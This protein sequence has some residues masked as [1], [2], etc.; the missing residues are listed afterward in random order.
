MNKLPIT[1]QGFEKLSQELKHLKMIE[2]PAVITALAEAKDY[3]DLL[4]NSDYYAAKE[5]QG[6]IEGR[7][8][9]LEDK[10][11]RSEIIDVSKLS[12]DV[13]KFG[14]KVNLV[15]LNTDKQVSYQIVGEYE[16]A[17]EN[18][19]ISLHAPIAKAMVG[20]VKDDIVEV[21]VPSGI[22]EYKILEVNFA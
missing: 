13:I 1:I 8:L 16:S 3:G 14:A 7:I 12:G 17:L 22:K 2:R 10:L 11:A 20:K 5:R 6:F 19:K 21:Q 15:D 4:E 9:Y 18:G